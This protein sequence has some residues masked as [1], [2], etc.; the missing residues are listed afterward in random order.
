MRIRLVLLT[1]LLLGAL[2]VLPLRAAAQAP[3]PETVTAGSWEF[4]LTYAHTVQELESGYY[5]NQ[6]TYTANPGYI[7]LELMVKIRSTDLAQA[8]SFKSTDLTMSVVD[9][10]GAEFPLEGTGSGFSDYCMLGGCWQ[11]WEFAEA[12]PETSVELLFTVSS[13]QTDPNY[14]LKIDPDITMSF[15]VP[16]V[17]DFGAKFTAETAT[18]VASADLKPITLEN[19]ASLA[20]LSSR[21]VYGTYLDDLT[22]SADGSRLVSAGCDLYGKS[23]CLSSVVRTWT[24]DSGALASTVVLGDT[25]SGGVYSVKFSADGSLMAGVDWDMNIH[26]WDLATGEALP[27]TI[28]AGSVS[29]LIVSPD[30]TR[31]AACGAENAITFWDTATGKAG[32][33]LTGP[34]VSGIFSP[35]G[36]WLATFG[37]NP[38]YGSG[39][40]LIHVWDVTGGQAVATIGQPGNT[41]MQSTF[42]FSPDHL[43]LASGHPSSY[44]GGDGMI[45]LWDTSSGAERTVWHQSDAS[46]A[47]VGLAF[48]PDGSLLVTAEENGILH[49]WD[50]S[51]GK[52]VATLGQPD[53]SPVSSM[54]FNASGTLLAVGRSGA[55]VE[56][57]GVPAA[58]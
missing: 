53:S 29:G 11:S 41:L 38:A 22:F 37:G 40:G 36:K 15:T 5:P 18:P 12:Y 49:I 55:A 1:S 34:C 44:D 46:Q 3:D 21:T 58:P 56:L 26:L 50:V 25:T 19:A 54:A 10:S 27:G 16:Y 24:L 43:L 52:E 45:H 14:T 9:A 8:T 7:F 2:A 6:T 4:T 33:T 35:D 42:V 57:W 32:T 20:A 30:G 39:D 51:T 13:E 23:G 47:V 31:L 28:A 48:S 17:A